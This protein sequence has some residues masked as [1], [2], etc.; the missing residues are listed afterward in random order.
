MKRLISLL[1]LSVFASSV[2]AVG[3]VGA[4]VYAATPDS[5]ARDEICIGIG[6]TSQDGSP[7]GD[8]GAQFASALRAVINILSTIIGTVAVIMIM[9]AGVRFITSGGDSSKVAGAKSSVV[10]ALIGLV[11]V[12]M[13]QFIVQ[14]VLKQVS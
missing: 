5:K 3:P 4:N 10:Y 9:V 12:A 1:A 11:I 13:A 2:L 7:C 14:F 8:H 6:Q